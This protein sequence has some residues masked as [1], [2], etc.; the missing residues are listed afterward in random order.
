MLRYANLHFLICKWHCLSDL[1]TCNCTETKQS[2]VIAVFHIP[3][4]IYILSI[5]IIYYIYISVCVCVCV[6]FTINFTWNFYLILFV[7]YFQRFFRQFFTRGKLMWYCV[8][9]L[10]F[11]MSNISLWSSVGTTCYVNTIVIPCKQHGHTIGLI[12]PNC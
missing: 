10:V 1:C 2:L 11:T 9:D 3:F 7:R 4:I 5:Y 8:S 12:Q 6:V